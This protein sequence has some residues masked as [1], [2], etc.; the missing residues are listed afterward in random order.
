MRNAF[1]KQVEILA[2]KDPRVVLLMGDI[3]NRMFNQFQERFPD[4]LFQCRY[5]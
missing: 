1:A 3:G 4:S 5:R 2:E